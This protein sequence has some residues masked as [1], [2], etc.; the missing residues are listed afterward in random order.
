M[1]KFLCLLFLVFTTF[2][3]LQAQHC[4]Y[5]GSYMIAVYLVDANGN[6]ATSPEGLVLK[7]KFNPLADSCTYAPGQMVIPFAGAADSLLKK[8]NG[9]WLR[10][11][12]E[13]AQDAE[14]MNPGNYVVVLNMAQHTCMLKKGN[15]F[16]YLPR[17]FSIAINGKTT[18][19]TEESIYSLCTNAGSWHRIRP[20]VIMKE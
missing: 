18:D 8:Y 5:D 1:K 7:E 3:G 6:P 19:I 9:H 11:A 13:R 12:G 10:S 16:R 15:D 4:P 2:R 20:L 17:H 14:F